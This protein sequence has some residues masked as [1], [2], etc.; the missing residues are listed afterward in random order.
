MILS[1]CEVSGFRSLVACAAGENPLVVAAR[2]DARTG[3]GGIPLVDAVAARARYRIVIATFGKGMGVDRRPFGIDEGG[4]G[5][6]R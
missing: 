4:A 5:A 6:C 3:F 2:A 1:G